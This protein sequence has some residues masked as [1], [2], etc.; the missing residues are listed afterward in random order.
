MQNIIENA[1]YF[2]FKV[3]ITYRHKRC[4]FAMSHTK[5]EIKQNL[6]IDAKNRQIN[7]FT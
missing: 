6:F 7:Y 5:I 1:S 4:T 3:M 2:S